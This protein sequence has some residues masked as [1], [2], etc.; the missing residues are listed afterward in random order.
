MTITVSLQTYILNDFDK[1]YFECN[2]NNLPIEGKLRELLEDLEDRLLSTSDSTLT[3]EYEEAYEKGHE[4]GFESGEDYGRME[5][6][7]EGYESGHTEGYDQA[8]SD[9]DIKV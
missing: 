4:A 8:I 7:N 9:Y 1:F 6:Y 2:W 3:S 5:G